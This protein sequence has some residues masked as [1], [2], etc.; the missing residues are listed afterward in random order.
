MHANYEVEWWK[1]DLSLNP[2]TKTKTKPK[3]VKNKNRKCEKRRQIFIDKVDTKR[4]KQGYGI[5]LFFKSM[6]NKV[7]ARYGGSLLESQ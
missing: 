4:T 5:R 7:N 2:N 3:E 1:K 6:L